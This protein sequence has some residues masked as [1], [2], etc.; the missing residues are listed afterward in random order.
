[1][2]SQAP[3]LKA[4]FVTAIGGLTGIT[5]TPTLVCYGEP[6]KYQPDD[7]I[8]VTDVSSTHVIATLGANRRREETLTATVVVSCYRGGDDATGAT[9]QLTT[10]RAWTLTGL[11]VDYVQVT[12]PTISGTVRG[13]TGEITHDLVEGFAQSADGINS[14]R[15]AEITTT[16]TFFA[17]I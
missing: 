14:G 8:A 13:L 2:S 16:F 10:E 4:A 12:D 7:I 5:G 3:A 6:G 17:R 1:M 9:Q 11:I 15:I